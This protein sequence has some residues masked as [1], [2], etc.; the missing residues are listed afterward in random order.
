MALAVGTG[1]NATGPADPAMRGSQSRDPVKPR[2]APGARE[3]G[4]PWFIYIP[5]LTADCP[6]FGFDEPVG[7]LPFQTPVETCQALGRRSAFPAPHGHRTDLHSDADDGSQRRSGPQPAQNGSGPPERPQALGQGHAPGFRSCAPLARFECSVAPAQFA[8]SLPKRFEVETVLW[9]A[10]AAEVKKP[11]PIPHARSAHDARLREARRDSS[12]EC[13][14]KKI[15]APGASKAERTQGSCL[16]TTATFNNLPPSRASGSRA[17]VPVATVALRL[18]RAVRMM[19]DFPASACDEAWLRVHGV[20]SSFRTEMLW[21]NENFH[22]APPAEGIEVDVSEAL[23]RLRIKKAARKNAR[24]ATVAQHV[25]RGVCHME[26]KG[27]ASD[28]L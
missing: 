11:P 7:I 28:T 26:W 1:A 14:S 5:Y 20:L 16:P 21:L 13:C 15:Q 22:L 18:H 12:L 4:D 27:T 19:E 2:L 6:D 17:V 8:L 23:K 25:V 10:G 24:N 3:A 9:E